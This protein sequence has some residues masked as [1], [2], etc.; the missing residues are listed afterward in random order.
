MTFNVFFYMFSHFLISF[1]IEIFLP[2][3][4]IQTVMI[5]SHQ[6][7]VVITT[8]LSIQHQGPGCVGEMVPRK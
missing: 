8:L 2:H 5:L 6:L 7:G 4:D 3:I 1:L